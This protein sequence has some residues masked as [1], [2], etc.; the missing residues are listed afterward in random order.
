[1]D[2][3]EKA[4][5]R[6]E[7]YFHRGHSWVRPEYDETVTVGLDDFAEQLM[8]QHVEVEYPPL[9][10]HLRVNGVGWRLRK[11]GRAVRVLSPVDGIVVGLGGPERDWYLRVKLDR[12]LE[13]QDHLLRGEEVGIWLAHERDRLQQVLSPLDIGL[14]LADGGMLVDDLSTV[15]PRDDWDK[16]VGEMLLEP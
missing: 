10:T 5:A 8:G 6:S 7:R 15:M 3:S 16:T 2:G 11:D 4:V 14:T 13:E 1:M 9:G 12:P